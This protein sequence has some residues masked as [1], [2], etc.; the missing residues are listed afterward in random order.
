VIKAG[1]AVGLGHAALPRLDNSEDCRLSSKE[2]FKL[3]GQTK[4]FCCPQ[5]AILPE[6]A[7]ISLMLN[8]ISAPKLG[9][10]FFDGHGRTF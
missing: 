5:I 3:P 8:L 1:R 2:A 7:C 4:F 9:G 10:H 6:P